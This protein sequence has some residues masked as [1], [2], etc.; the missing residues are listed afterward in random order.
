ML[1]ASNCCL[2]ASSV[3]LAGDLASGEMMCTIMTG[4]FG[5]TFST[6]HLD[7]AFAWAFSSF[8]SSSLRVWVSCNDICDSKASLKALNEVLQQRLAPR[9]KE[10][11]TCYELLPLAVCSQHLGSPQVTSGG[12]YLPCWDICLCDCVCVCVSTNNA[13]DIYIYIYIQM[14]KGTVS[15]NTGMIRWSFMCH[16]SPFTPHRASL[17][18]FVCTSSFLNMMCGYV[19]KCMCIWIHCILCPIHDMHKIILY[20]TS[21]CMGHISL[22]SKELRERLGSWNLKDKSKVH[23]E[24]SLVDFWKNVSWNCAWIPLPGHVGCYSSDVW[25]SPLLI[26]HYDLTVRHSFISYPRCG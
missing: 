14:H 5:S 25:D 15:S 8:A 26:R 2:S 3:L 11:A 9:V 7:S 12:R 6:S 18:V 4:L 22:G 1:C 10:I 19:Y 24:C 21:S 17:H 16:F 13:F 23:S 20:H